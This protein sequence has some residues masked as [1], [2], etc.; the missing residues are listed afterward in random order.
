MKKKI[1]IFLTMQP[2]D[3]GK[4]QYTVNLLENIA[5]LSNNSLEIIG[6]HTSS[7]WEK[8][9]KL[10]NV[11]GYRIDF[12]ENIWYL[13]FRKLF[14]EVIPLLSL[15]RKFNKYFS[16]TYKLLKSIGPDLIFFP[17]GESLS[18]EFEFSSIVPV[19]DLM[20][21]YEK[22][23]EVTEKKIFNSRERHYRNV[24]KYVDGIMVDSELGKRHVLDNYVVNEKKIF[25]LPYEPSYYIF[26]YNEVKVDLKKSNL[27]ERY[28]FYPAQFW[29]HKNH[30]I[31][32]EAVK[33]LN[34][35]GLKIH[36]VFV[37]A[38]K[39]GYENII[40]LLKKYE[41]QDQFSILGYVNN[42]EIVALYQNAE[43]L[44]FPS[45]FG[46]TNIPP[47]EALA[48]GC[49]VLVSDVYAHRQQLGDNAIYFNP[50]D[51]DDL[52]EKL[53]NIYQ[54]PYKVK[55]KFRKLKLENLNTLKNCIMQISRIK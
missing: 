38:Q 5:N 16:K 7:V 42:C 4:F 40:E 35:K 8:Y 49:T 41:L 28:F 24:A 48:V 1:I 13:R 37:G 19:F 11:D 45:F 54:N 39:N 51:A 2:E 17:G 30:K 22:F 43:A 31:I 10:F 25:I 34:A 36:F 29:K 33:K 9:L 14:I 27:P 26:E 18:Y 20:H 6:L 23:P 44:V 53:L 15:W 3:G 52:M 50:N 47:I 21:K 12:V 55:V 46:P 32:I